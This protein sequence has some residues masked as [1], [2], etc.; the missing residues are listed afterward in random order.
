M[1]QHRAKKDRDFGG[2]NGVVEALS[3]FPDQFQRSVE[4]VQTLPQTF[5]PT[6][7]DFTPVN[8]LEED[9]LTLTGYSNDADGRTMAVRNLRDGEVLHSWT[10]PDT[11]GPLQPHWRAHH[12]ILLEDKSVVSFITNRSPLFRLDSASNV[13][14]RQDSLSFHHAINRAAEAVCGVHHALGAGWPPHR[15]PGPVPHGRPDRAFP[16]Q[17]RGAHRC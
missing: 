14:W 15:I 17:Q 3:G 4:E 7:A 5:V 12:Q 10:L 2:L 13:V 16:G 8:R 11:L 6:P 1:A 9:V